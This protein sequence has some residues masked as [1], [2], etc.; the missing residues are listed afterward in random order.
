MAKK[1]SIE[2]VQETLDKDSVWRKL[3]L[4][5]LKAILQS[6]ATR[7]REQDLFCRA[8]IT[9]AY[10]HWEGFTKYGIGIVLEYVSNLEIKLEDIND[11]LLA[12]SLHKKIQPSFEMNSSAALTQF[13]RTIRKG[14]SENFRFNKKNLNKQS[15]NE[16]AFRNLMI[17]IGIECD[18]ILSAM[19]G[20]TDIN[21]GERLVKK[22][23]DI[24]HGEWVTPEKTECI[25]ILESVQALIDALKDNLINY[26][27]SGAYSNTS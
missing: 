1:E 16:K 19:P 4:G 5:T 20:V 24:A 13:V 12:H 7:D 9:L 18:T 3:E 11:G 17:E 10:A 25:K 8:S 21:I 23:N 2:K 26:L 14:S 15:L 27:E 6:E 22:R